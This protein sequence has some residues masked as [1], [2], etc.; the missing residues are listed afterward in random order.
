[1]QKYGRIDWTSLRDAFTSRGWAEIGGD[2]AWGNVKFGQTRPDN[3]ISG[4]QT[5]VLLAYAFYRQQSGLTISQIKDPGFRI[6]LREF[7]DAV[8]AF[9]LSTG[10]FFSNVVLLEGPA[11]YDVIVTYENLILTSQ[12]EAQLRQGQPLLMFY[13]DLNIT[14]NYPFAILQGDWVTDEQQEAAGI[15]RDFLL[16]EQ[17]QRQALLSGFRPNNPN[18]HITDRLSGN[19]FLEQPSGIQIETQTEPLAQVPSGEVL[20][21]IISLWQKNYPNPS[22]A[23]G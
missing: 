15:F 6:F 18:V 16:S 8:H 21:E 14:S 3:S 4:L 7:E 9:G 12:R 20:N 10:T 1:M 23:S 2:P 5:I 22:T 13:P 19:P 11:A 17:Q